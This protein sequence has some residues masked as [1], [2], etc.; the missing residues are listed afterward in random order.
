[1]IQVISPA[2]TPQALSKIV[3]L[4]RQSRK[5]GTP[6]HIIGLGKP[7]DEVLDMLQQLSIGDKPVRFSLL[8]NDEN[9]TLILRILESNYEAVLPEQ[10]I[11]QH[12]GENLKLSAGSLR[13]DTERSRKLCYHRAFI[14][15][16]RSADITLEHIDSTKVAV[17]SEKF[18]SE[19][20]GVYPRFYQ[21]EILHDYRLNNTKSEQLVEKVNKKFE[22]MM[23]GIYDMLANP[24]ISLPEKAV[25]LSQ[26]SG[27]SQASIIPDE[28][29][30]STDLEVARA[31][32]RVSSQELAEMELSVEIADSWIENVTKMESELSS[33]HGRLVDFNATLSNWHSEATEA[34]ESSKVKSVEH[35]IILEDDE[36]LNSFYVRH[37]SE[38]AENINLWET[39]MSITEGKETVEQARSRLE[40]IT[41]RAV[42]QL[43]D[44]FSL[45]EYLMGQEYP[46]LRAYEIG[47]EFYAGQGRQVIFIGVDSHRLRA[48]ESYYSNR[49]NISPKIVPTNNFAELLIIT[50]TPEP[51]EF[52]DDIYPFD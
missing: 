42:E 49:L 31:T 51:L 3:E 37:Q 5:S 11:E 47:Q 52:K 25:F 44:S 2:D 13:Y 48:L 6:L 45:A 14:D 29:R 17:F 39:F 32:D 34:F 40:S 41:H 8:E 46:Y 15:A 24:Q 35:T 26:M 1:M 21:E 33:L 10:F 7:S 20:N 16:L 30:K 43:F 38:L 9:L 50:V 28:I 12:R 27:V 19:I 36:N 18:L 4:D 22:K 23:A